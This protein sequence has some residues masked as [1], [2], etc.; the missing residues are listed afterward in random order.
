VIESRTALL[1]RLEQARDRFAGGDVPRPPGWVGY[2]L[3]PG[4]I[5]FWQH[6]DHR[7]HDRRRHTRAAD[8][9]WSSQLLAP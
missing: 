4:M 1:A 5:E 8:G 3:A 6:G 9:S 7:L 2:L